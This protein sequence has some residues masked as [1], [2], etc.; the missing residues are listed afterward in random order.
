MQDD[1]ISTE[2]QKIYGMV[3]VQMKLELCRTHTLRTVSAF[4]PAH[5]PTY[6]LDLVHM[7]DDV[8]WY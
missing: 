7:Q 5:L 3:E 1:V 4:L 6:L 2:L 8:I